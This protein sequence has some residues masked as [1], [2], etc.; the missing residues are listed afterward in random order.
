MYIQR[1]GF[2]RITTA[3]HR[4]E[5]LILSPTISWSIEFDKIKIIF[6]TSHQQHFILFL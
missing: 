4:G 6:I 2:Y 1:D 3:L 5:G